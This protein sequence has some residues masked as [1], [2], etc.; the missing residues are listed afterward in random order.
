MCGLKAAILWFLV[1]VAKKL[2]CLHN[3]IFLF[4][5]CQ[6]LQQQ[7]AAVAAARELTLI[8]N[9]ESHYIRTDRSIWVQE[10]NLTP[11]QRLALRDFVEWNALPENRFYRY[12][13]VLDNCSTRVRD[14]IDWALGGQIRRQTEGEPSGTTYREHTRRL[15]SAD[16]VLYTGLMLGLGASVDEPI[17][18][19][20]EMF[21]PGKVKA[22]VEELSVAGPDGVAV[23]LVGREQVLHQ[24][25]ARAPAS[26]TPPTSFR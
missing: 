10:L 1:A 6:A 13:Y 24:A 11:Q 14:A 18:Q 22:R 4:R 19:W 7:F 2:N 17:S 5:L 16:P 23:P 9:A 15:T 25:V 12:D 8:V 26:V 3:I 20:E 21:L